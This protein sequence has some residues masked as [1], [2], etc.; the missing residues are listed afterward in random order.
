VRCLLTRHATP[1]IGCLVAVQLLVAKGASLAST[2]HVARSGFFRFRFR[3]SIGRCPNL[4]TYLIVNLDCRTAST[5]RPV[6]TLRRATAT[7]PSSS[8]CANIRCVPVVAY[9]TVPDYYYYPPP[10]LVPRSL[11]AA[12]GTWRAET[13]AR[14]F[15]RHCARSVIC[16]LIISDDLTTCT[17]LLSIYSHVGFSNIRFSRNKMLRC[18]AVTLRYRIGRESCRVWNFFQKKMP[19]RLP[20]RCVA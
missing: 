20:D 13:C 18:R 3:S 15:E 4:S 19:F 11:R 2:R 9:L 7:S 10:P 1:R 5:A 17:T 6:C 8:S 12:A 16:H 14:Q